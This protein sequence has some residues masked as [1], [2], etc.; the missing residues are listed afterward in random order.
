M[1]EYLE[2]IRPHEEAVFEQEKQGLASLLDGGPS[3]EKIRVVIL[4]AGYDTR[5]A[6]ELEDVPELRGKPKA[7]FPVGDRTILDMIMAGLKHSALC[8]NP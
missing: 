6:A 4:A 3:P 8:L 5:L 7:L 2:S 1:D